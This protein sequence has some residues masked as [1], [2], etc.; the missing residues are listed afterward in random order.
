MHVTPLPPREEHPA[1]LRLRPGQ[2]TTR[3]DAT[4]H[5]RGVGHRCLCQ[6]R[7]WLRRR[8]GHYGVVVTELEK[9]A[10]SW[11]IWRGPHWLL[12]LLLL[13]L[14]QFHCRGEHRRLPNLH[15]NHFHRL[16]S[17]G[18]LRSRILWLRH[19]IR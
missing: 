6:S 12:L 15:P 3:V 2:A 9:M 7:M 13:L 4:H 18:E 8:R 19:A 10:G 5:S 17:A 16:L 1:R 11:K 14:S